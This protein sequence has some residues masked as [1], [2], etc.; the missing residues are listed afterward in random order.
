MRYCQQRLAET[1]LL[2]AKQNANT[3]SN[4]ENW[5][6]DAELAEAE[7]KGA[8]KSNNDEINGQ[9]EHSNIFCD[10]HDVL[11]RVRIV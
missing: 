9:Q 1:C 7:P 10:V 8:T 11:L 6:N 2:F 3:G 5:H 4:C